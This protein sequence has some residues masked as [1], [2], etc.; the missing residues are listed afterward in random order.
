MN[1]PIGDDKD[2]RNSGRGILY[3]RP[4]K[5]EVMVSMVGPTDGIPDDMAYRG[6]IPFQEK[7]PTSRQIYGDYITRATR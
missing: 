7:P 5:N 4:S 6:K 1:F 2:E 3:L